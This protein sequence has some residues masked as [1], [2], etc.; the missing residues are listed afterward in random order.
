MNIYNKG[1]IVEYYTN[2]PDCKNTLE[3]WYHDVLTKEWKKPNSVTKDFNKARTIKNNRA[4]FEINGND[5]RLIAELNY[6]KGWVFIKFIGTHAEY[7][8]VDSETID[9]YKKKKK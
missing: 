8:K 5:Y 7:D 6:E 4:I 2:H 9:L 3:K 1:T